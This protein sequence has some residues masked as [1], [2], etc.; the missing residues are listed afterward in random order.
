MALSLLVMTTG[1][2]VAAA[3]TVANPRLVLGYPGAAIPLVFTDEAGVV[4]S[5]LPESYGEQRDRMITAVFP[6]SATWRE[7]QCT[8]TP[9]KSGRLRIKLNATKVT[10]NGKRA[11]ATCLFDDLKVND[12]P[13]PNG[14]FED[15][16]AHFTFDPGRDGL[17]PGQV[18][19]DSELAYAGN[20]CLTV[21]DKGG[22]FF[23]Y[24]VEA[25]VPVTI[26]FLYCDGG[27]L[28]PETTGQ[29]HE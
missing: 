22:A 6:S 16:A 17:P 2:R 9:Q 21:W 20:A 26:S 12:Q 25:K 11:A 14:S 15:G 8:V 27:I 5:Q 3:E 24:E 7:A 18:L 29:A 4:K 23:F 1:L 13:L 28:N 10:V 19:I